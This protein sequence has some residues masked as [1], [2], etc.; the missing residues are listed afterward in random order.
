M[1]APLQNRMKPMMAMLP[2]LKS[3]VVVP[4][5]LSASGQTVL[6]MA[7]K[8]MG[9]INVPPGIHFMNFMIPR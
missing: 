4:P 5:M 9:T 3:G 1:D 6:M 8:S 7:V 2:F